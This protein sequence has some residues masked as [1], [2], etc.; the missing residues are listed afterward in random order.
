MMAGRESFGFLRRGGGASA[1]LSVRHGAPVTCSMREGCL[2]ECAVNSP[3][4]GAAFAADA[5]LRLGMWPGRRGSA[6]PR[7]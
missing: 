5:G 2:S 6:F 7:C 3:D 1:R 4:S